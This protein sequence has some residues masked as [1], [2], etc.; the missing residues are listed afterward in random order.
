VINKLF[1][2]INC[3]CRCSFLY[4]ISRLYITIIQ[5]LLA[6]PTPR[7]FPNRN[8][9]FVNVFV[10][11]TA[12]VRCKAVT[13]ADLSSKGCNFACRTCTV[14]VHPFKRFATKRCKDAPVSFATCL[15]A[16][17]NSKTTERILFSEDKGSMLLRNIVCTCRSSTVQQSKRRN[18]ERL[19]PPGQ[20]PNAVSA[21]SDLYNLNRKGSAE[22]EI[23]Q[24]AEW[25]EFSRSVQSSVAGSTR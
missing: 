19:S 21:Q 22:G 4:C 13:V 23:S 3:L 6:S 18:I 9:N 8:A 24:W 16:Y 2:L 25:A 5:Q 20:N 10:C 14:R 15:P 17:N 11:P 7:G 12:A 1:V